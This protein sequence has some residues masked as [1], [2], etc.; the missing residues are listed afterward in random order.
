MDI[1]WLSSPVGSVFSN[2]GHLTYA[3]NS[4]QIPKANLKLKHGQAEFTMYVEK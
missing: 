2:A 1:T 3:W 4:T